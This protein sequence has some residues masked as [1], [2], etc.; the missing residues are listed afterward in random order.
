MNKKEKNELAEFIKN[1]AYLNHE[2][3]ESKIKIYE[4][5]FTYY[6]GFDAY[7]LHE[8]ENL[9]LVE[10]KKLAKNYAIKNNKTDNYT[11]AGFSDE[12]AHYNKNK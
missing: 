6:D 11:F 4:I 12:T 1:D 3:E 8:C 5:E 2:K 10:A 7:F 9:T